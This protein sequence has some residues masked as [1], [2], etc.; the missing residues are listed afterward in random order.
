MTPTV[1]ISYSH[2]SELHKDWVLQLAT[3]LRANGVD[4]LLD[5]WNLKLGQ[6]LASFMERGLSSSNRVLCICTEDYII[7]SNTGMGGAGY[8]KQIITAELLADLN[9]NW[10]IPVVR[11]NLPSKKVPTFLAG[12]LYIDFND[13]TLYESHYEEILRELLDEPILPVPPL[14]LNPFETI[15][16]YAKQKFIPSNEKYVSPAIKGR[17]TFDYSNNNGHYYIGQGNLAFELNFSKSSDESIQLYN[18]PDSIKTVA[19]AK[20]KN[21]ITEIN[22]ARVYD[23]SSRVRRPKLN[24]IAVLQ[25]ING[26]YAAIKIL[27]IKDDTRGA[28]Y[29]EVT[30]DYMIQTDG[31]PDFTSLA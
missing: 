20:D 9:T 15:K 5:R 8:E 27:S 23:G 28:E 26:F 14:G 1:F 16:E 6:D 12:R 24:Q 17:V 30:F 22:D 29:D 21:S 19:I 2:D 18:D 31:S 11:N 3:R 10:V 4:V 7:K 25:N 13:D